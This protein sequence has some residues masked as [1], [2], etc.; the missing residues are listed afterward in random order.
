MRGL[1]VVVV[2]AAGLLLSASPAPAAPTSASCAGQFFSSH[3]GLAAQH[4]EPA[5]VGESVSAT[6][7]EWAVSSARASAPHATCHGKTA[8]SD[9]PALD[10]PRPQFD[11]TEICGASAGQGLRESTATM[12]CEQC[13]RDHDPSTTAPCHRLS[14]G[15]G[16]KLG[17]SRLGFFDERCKVG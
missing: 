17:Q 5:N 12:A 9:P 1:V 16:P 8:D 3:P 14:C 7:Q 6:A 2:T 11:P 15:T 13:R 10:Q 4:T